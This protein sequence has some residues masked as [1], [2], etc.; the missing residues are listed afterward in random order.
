IGINTNSLR[1]LLYSR[2][3]GVSFERTVTV[4]RQTLSVHVDDLPRVFDEFGVEMAEG[5]AR[6][7]HLAGDGYAEPLFIRL[8]ARIAESTDASA[9]EGATIVHDMNLPVA[10]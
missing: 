9:Y 10:P 3:L 4:G 7:L 5:E 2:T 1:F 6:D 8:G